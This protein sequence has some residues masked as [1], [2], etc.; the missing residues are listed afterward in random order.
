M[1]GPISKSGMTVSGK[2]CHMVVSEVAN[3]SIVAMMARPAVKKIMDE[4]AAKAQK[5]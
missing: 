5:H 1:R 3:R 2:P 4:K